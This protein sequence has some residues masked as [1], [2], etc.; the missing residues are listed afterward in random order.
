MLAGIFPA[1]ILYSYGVFFFQTLGLVLFFILVRQGVVEI[2][3][4]LGIYN[5]RL[6]L[7]CLFYVG[8]NQVILL[9]NILPV[10]RS[11]NSNS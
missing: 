9:E 10:C 6:I 3:Y 5:T 4:G 7:T 11:V 2:G 1:N 8:A